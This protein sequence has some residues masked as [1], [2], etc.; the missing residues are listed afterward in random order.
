MINIGYNQPYYP[1]TF[2]VLQHVDCLQLLYDRGE[3]IGD[4]CDHDEEGEEEDEDGGHD[5][6]DVLESDS[7]V[8]QY[9]SSTSWTLTRV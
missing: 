7:P 5:E 3:G 8:F 1:L 4:D 9:S 2:L 6:H